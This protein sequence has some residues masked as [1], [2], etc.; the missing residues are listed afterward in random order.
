MSLLMEL[1][2]IMGLA[3]V[4]LGELDED[5][6]ED[7]SASHETAACAPTERL[8]SG[9]DW[10]G[11][12]PT[13]LKHIDGCWWC[14]LNLLADRGHLVARALRAEPARE[15]RRSGAPLTQPPDL[16]WRLGGLA[17]LNTIARTLGVRRKDLDRYIGEAKAALAADGIMLELARDGLPESEALATWLAATAPPVV[18][19][20]PRLV[21]LRLANT[22][23]L[24]LELRA[25]EVRGDPGDV[26]PEDCVLQLREEQREDG[27]ST[28]LECDVPAESVAWRLA[29]RPEDE[30]ERL[31]ETPGLSLDRPQIGA[32]RATHGEA[33]FRD[34]MDALLPARRGGFGPEETT[35][36]RRL[37]G[38]LPGPPIA[39]TL[40]VD[41]GA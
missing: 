37:P 5:G 38:R 7:A 8:R 3:D 15:A 28:R 23:T 22:P 11:D 27:W 29:F 9:G 1:D 20:M 17:Q 2:R 26:F 30:A 39:Y 25:T 14:R 34:L 31:Y 21:T 18:M 35:W 12:A 19:E 24:E 32:L 10:G 16:L 4:A 13:T 6:L 36:S 40:R 41:F 33:A